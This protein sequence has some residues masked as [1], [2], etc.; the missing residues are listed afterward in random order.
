MDIR[1]RFEER[2]PIVRERVV[3]TVD[4]SAPQV[5]GAAR[6]AQRVSAARALAAGGAGA[7]A[8]R[9][10]TPAIIT[11]DT[12][13]L[14]NLKRAAHAK[15]LQVQAL[16]AKIAALAERLERVSAVFDAA[17]HAPT[18]D[19]NA[20]ARDRVRSGTPD[21]GAEDAR[22]AIEAARTVRHAPAQSATSLE[23]ILAAARA[24][25]AENGPWSA[26]EPPRATANGGGP[27]S[28]E[29]I[30]AAAR[31]GGGG[32]GGGGGKYSKIMRDFK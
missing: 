22:R 2:P 21:E 13:E 3:S 10:R 18:F 11:G 24:P 4:G 7:V 29:A 5:G 27:S 17:Q 6:A 30:L 14:R 15:E 25:R 1:S 19:A 8:R 32:G 31:G 12:E 26:G 23:A 20:P 16:A 28:L 9:R